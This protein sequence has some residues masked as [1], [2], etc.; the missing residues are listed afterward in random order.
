MNR[1]SR[2]VA[3]AAG[4]AA[5]LWLG[6]LAGHAGRSSVPEPAAR[7]AQPAAPERRVLYWYDPMKP[8]VHFDHPGPSPFMDMK[9]LP[10]YAE[11][12]S[13]GA[14]VPGYAP[15]TIPPGRLQEIGA[16]TEPAAVRSLSGTVTTNGTVA[17][18]ESLR[19]DVNVK[20]SGWVRKLR[21]ERTGD[22]VR[23]GDP[24]LTVYS[25]DLVAT[26]RELLLALDNERRL[27][28]S[29]NAEAA[30]DAA[31]LTAA[32]RDRLRLWDVPDAEIERIARTGETRT[33]IPI[34]SPATGTVVAKNAVEGMAI[35]PGMSLFSIADLSRVWILA[36][37]YA[38]ELPLVRPGDAADISLSSAGGRHLMGRVDFLY[39]TVNAETRTGRVRIVVNNP[40][41][42][43][44]PGMFA[45]VAIHGA[46][47]EALAVPRT[48][49]IDTGR[50]S[51]AFVETSPGRFEPRELT[52][53]QS[54]PDFVEVRAGL[55]AGER[56]VTSANFLIDSESRIGAVGTPPPGSAGQ[57][58]KPSPE[59]PPPSP[60]ERR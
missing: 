36:D 13:A 56:V 12:G 25:P 55:R 52:V 41:G 29:G 32:S 4:G 35:S 28:G 30:R 50:R 20:F 22:R 46:S 58:P 38:P 27:A 53:G 51:I 21:V 47:R 59:M 10:K 8:E 48:A 42:E 31:R 18:D 57:P 14:A 16:T 24:L 9:L 37:L 11:E 17:E 54:T 44:R 23:R 26:E 5:L 60:E 2:I 39:P 49:V 34:V 45:T 33:E 19:F 7:A 40:S 15:V 6:Y 43:I 1:S 3:F